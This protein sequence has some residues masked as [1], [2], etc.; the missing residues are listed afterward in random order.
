MTQ[1]EPNIRDYDEEYRRF[2][3]NVPKVY[4]FAWDVIDK[5]AESDKLALV[6]VD[7][8]GEG[9]TEH[10]YSML[11][12]ASKRLARVLLNMGIK[13]GDRVLVM[14]PRIPEFYIS[15]LGLIRIGAIPMPTPTLSAPKDIHYR[16][17]RSQAIGVITIEDYAQRVEEVELLLPT[18][19]FKM[20]MRGERSMW[21]SLPAMMDEVEPDLRREEVEKTASSDP[22]LIFFTSGTEGYPKMVLHTHGYPIGHYITAYMV[23]DVHREDLIW[24]M[25]DTG[26]AKTAYGK[27]FGQ[28]ILGA[29]VM[30]HDQRGRFDPKTVIKI[31]EK[32]APTIFCAAP[33]VYR[34]LIQEPS[35]KDASFPN[36]RHSL[37]AGEPLNP[38]VIRVWK[39]VTGSDI[40][41]FYGQSETVALI[42]NC[43]AFP[44]RPGS[45]GKATLGHVIKI[46]DDDL[47]ELPVGEEGHIALKISPERPPGLMKEYWKNPEG[48]ESCFRNG[49]YLTGDKAYMD[50]DGYFWFVG[51]AD[52]VIKA[53]G[54]R[55]SP[56]EVESVLIEHPA[57]AEAAVIGVPH[58]VRGQVLKAYIIL[59]RGYE[60]SKELAAELQE[61]VK[62]NTAPYKYPRIVEFVND[63]PKTISGKIQRK[64]LRKMEEMMAKNKKEGMDG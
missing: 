4:N 59:A 21:E 16:I 51:R 56:F 37:S 5:Q 14:I 39:D 49:W 7:Q 35:L 12:D 22:M 11:S 18:L 45:M 43:R 52:D 23:M 26:W 1:W 32:H 36:L 58:P 42:G 17:D 46:L 27:F 55:I 30:Q 28:F 53:S 33:T 50:K 2:R 10:T 13:K 60:P 61:F 25:A 48:N 62:K 31:L 44:I 57:V 29:A 38:E 24:S 63:L 41:E 47:N 15:M 19:K 6:S 20:L 8:D 64:I 34:M 40:Y 3:W 54:Y 9:R